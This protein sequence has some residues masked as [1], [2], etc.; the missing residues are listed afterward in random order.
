MSQAKSQ[1]PHHSMIY[2]EKLEI[3]KIV[4]WFGYF[5]VHIALRLTNVFG[6]CNTISGN[7]AGIVGE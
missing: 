7:F 4:V 2:E 1:H 3:K 5:S 6:K